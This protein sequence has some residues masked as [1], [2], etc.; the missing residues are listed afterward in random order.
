MILFLDL[1][2]SNR[3]MEFCNDAYCIA[4]FQTIILEAMNRYDFPYIPIPSIFYP[5]ESEIPFRHCA[6]CNEELIDSNREYFIE[7]AL[8]PGD[9]IYE[10]AICY[11]CAETAQQTMSK[12]SLERAND[13]MINRMKLLEHRINM[14]DNF[15]LE[16]AFWLDHCVVD[17]TPIDELGEYQI[18]AHCQGPN[19]LFS[20]FPYCLGARAAE[21]LVSILSAETLEELDRIGDELI[22]IPPELRSLWHRKPMLV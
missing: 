8:K 5:F 2:K 20:V 9:T 21:E 6:R 4:S 16:Y 3:D 18:M 7:K 22:D 10:Y 19:M 11:Q 15:H 17:D 14:L 12:A 13:F 1:A